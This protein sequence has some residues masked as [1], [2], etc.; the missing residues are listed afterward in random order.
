MEKNSAFVVIMLLISSCMVTMCVGDICATDRDCVEIGF[1]IC[2]NTG[3]M[4]ICYNGYCS[5]YAPRRSPPPPR[6]ST[7]N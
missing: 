3:L 6:F 5:C 4:P 2:K 7:S 1:P